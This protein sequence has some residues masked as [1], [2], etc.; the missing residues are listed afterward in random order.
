MTYTEEYEND[1]NDEIREEKTPVG[2]LY[3][4]VFNLSSDAFL[5]MSD[6][7]LTSA[8][9]GWIIWDSGLVHQQ[10]GTSRVWLRAKND[11]QFFVIGCV[12][13]HTPRNAFLAN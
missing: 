2:L 1:D 3:E 8:F 5:L 11:N 7:L 4:E 6:C 12:S 13:C 9:W 10:C